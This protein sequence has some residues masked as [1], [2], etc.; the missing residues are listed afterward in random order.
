MKSVLPSILFVSLLFLNLARAQ[1]L[2]LNV[3]LPVEKY[4]LKY[5]LTVLLH[6]DTTTPLV[7]YH[8]W[9]KVG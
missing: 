6:R 5:G 9:Y 7:S 8:T 4:V 3:D 1:N 2:D